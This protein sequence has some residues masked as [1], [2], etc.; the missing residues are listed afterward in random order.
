MLVQLISVAGPQ[1]ERLSVKDITDLA[2]WIGADRS[3]CQITADTIV[4]VNTAS[5][6]Y[7]MPG[8]ATYGTTKAGVYMCK[9]DADAVGDKAAANGQ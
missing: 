3:L 6:I 8:T 1:V 4:W 5:G 2:N 9:A 7:H